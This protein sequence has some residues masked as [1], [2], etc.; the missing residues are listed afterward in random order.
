MQEECLVTKGYCCHNMKVSS[1]R[2]S[3]AEQLLSNHS[4]DLG[5]E[6][7]VN[8][9]YASTPAMIISVPLAA[10]MEE[11]MVINSSHSEGSQNRT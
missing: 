10:H 9:L 8:G 5:G 3:A 6:N 1:R 2:L 7:V 4:L 11:S